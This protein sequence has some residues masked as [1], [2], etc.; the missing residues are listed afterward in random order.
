M[1]L[2]NHP[3]I[4]EGKSAGINH[5]FNSNEILKY[6]PNKNYNILHTINKSEN[7]NNNNFV[8]STSN[9]KQDIWE[10]IPYNISIEDKRYQN[11]KN[12][13]SQD[14]TFNELAINIQDKSIREYISNKNKQSIDI[15][16]QQIKDESIQSNNLN[17]S[18][19]KHI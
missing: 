11:I 7:E 13:L 1:T 5:L 6:L 4:G 16:L 8:N 9:I 3:S 19:S 14:N 15:A 12:I 17:K 18:Y 10:I 2:Q